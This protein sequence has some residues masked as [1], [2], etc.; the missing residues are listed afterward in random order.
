[1][2]YIAATD[3][4]VGDKLLSANRHIARQLHRQSR[5][6]Q[7]DRPPSRGGRCSSAGRA[8]VRALAH[9][10]VTSPVQLLRQFLASVRIVLWPY[11]HRFL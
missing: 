9:R 10:V 3:L 7:T 2:R 1:M 6:P 11:P 5:T 4:R 8:E